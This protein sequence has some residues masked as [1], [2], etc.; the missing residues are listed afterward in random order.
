MDKDLLAYLNGGRNAVYGNFVLSREVTP[1]GVEH[2]FLKIPDTDICLYDF[3]YNP[4]KNRSDE[5][6]KHAGGK[7]PYV[8][9]FMQEINRL[10]ESGLTDEMV[11]SLVRLVDNITW[12]TGVLVNK[13]SKKALKFD[14]MVKLL[15]LSKAQASRRIKRLKEL[16]VLRQTDEGYAVAPNL[17][18]KGGG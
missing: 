12:S 14:D 1:T 16:D 15:G 10:R 4:K 8:K 7:K 6:P 2:V 11:G 17:I 3:W 5:K 18:K 13:R 9:L